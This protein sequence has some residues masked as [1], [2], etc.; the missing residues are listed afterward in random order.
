MLL[1]QVVQVNGSSCGGRQ[2]V[3]KASVISIVVVVCVPQELV[4]SLDRGC[5]SMPGRVQ[6]T[7]V[8]FRNV[9]NATYT[10]QRVDD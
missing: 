9:H 4:H 2:T 5:L 6:C 1:L 8:C 7:M 10:A 3:L